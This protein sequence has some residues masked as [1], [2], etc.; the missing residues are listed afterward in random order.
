MWYIR[1]ST[2]HHTNLQWQL[3]CNLWN[4]HNCNWK[5]K[6][7]VFELSTS[8]HVT[9]SQLTWVAL[10]SCMMANQVQTVL[11]CALKFPMADAQLIWPPVCSRLMPA[12]HTSTPGS[13]SEVNVVDWLLTTAAMY[14]V[15]RTCYL[16]C[17]SCCM[18]LS[19]QTYLCWTWHSCFYE[20]AEDTSF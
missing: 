12:D 19:F 7:M 2:N 10:A 15:W 20:T 14:Q 4:L 17:R 13:T 11:H 5:Y 8:D 1:S 6:R 3:K 9:A 16:T 18:E